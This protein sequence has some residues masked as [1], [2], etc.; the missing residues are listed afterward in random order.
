RKAIFSGDAM[1]H[2]LQIMEPTLHLPVDWD[3]A[4][5]AATRRKLLESC[6][7]KDTLL[8]TAHFPAPT[9]GRVVSSGDGFRF[10]FG[11]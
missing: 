4:K 10:E 11:T 1:H 6:A 5:A 7:D 9:A 2:P 3:V 8:M